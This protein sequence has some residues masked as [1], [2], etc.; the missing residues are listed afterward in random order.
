MSEIKSQ[1]NVDNRAF[2]E[3]KKAAVSRL[4]GRSAEEIAEKTA[5]VFNK[6]ESCLEMESLGQKIQIEYPSWELRKEPEAWHTHLILHYLEMADGAPL[7]EEWVTFGNLKDGLIRGTGFDR[8]VDMELE[9]I[10]KGKDIEDIKKLL[11][12]L[13]AEIV[14]GRADLSAVISICPRYPLLLNIWLEDEEFPASGKLLADKNADHY[15]TIEDAVTAGEIL[16]Q[17][18][19]DAANTI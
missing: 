12:T 9:K 1:T 5:V 2:Q 11:G 3:M 8:T 14:D 18:L 19:R 16:L 7:A 13:G 10:L 4:Q 15:L 6:E 17:R